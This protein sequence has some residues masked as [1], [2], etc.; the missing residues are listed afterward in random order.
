M[1][2]E[3]YINSGILHEY[4]IDTLSDSERAEVEQVCARYPEVRNELRQMQRAFEKFAESVG[5]KP[6]RDVEQT[7]W[8]TLEN[9]NKEKAGDLND[10]PLINKYS[11]HNNWRRIV[12]SLMP[13]PIPDKR[14]MLPLRNA[15]GVMQVLVISKTD[16][17]DEVHEREQESFLVLEGECECRIGDE[18]WRLGPC[19][20]LEIPLHKNHNVRVLSPYVVAVLQHVDI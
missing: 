17:D 18:T 11:N 10:L 13:S 19:G 7:I 4:C 16:V 20:F 2:T 12:K 3:A 9:I 6:A 14:V 5:K 8:G 1:N 15:N